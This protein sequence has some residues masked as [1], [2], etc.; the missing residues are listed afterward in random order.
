M[1][2]LLLFLPLCLAVACGSR[3]PTLSGPAPLPEHSSCTGRPLGAGNH[4]RTLTHQERT[5]NYRLHVPPGYDPTRPTP[6]VFA[7]HGFGSNEKSMGTLTHLSEESD[8]QGF[9]VVYVRGLTA[10]ELGRDPEPGF[11]ASGAWNSGVCCGAARDVGVDDV[12]FVDSLL[13]EL[14]TQVCLDTKRV[15][16]TGFSNGGFFSYRLA[17][18]RSEQFAAIAPVSG[19]ESATPCSPS[20][21]VPIMHFHGSEDRTIEVQG[22]T[23]SFLSGPYPAMS[24]VV[25]RWVSRDACTGEPRTTYQKGDSTCVTWESCA[26]GAAVTRCDIQGGGHTWPGGPDIPGLGYTTKDLDA[27][28][29]MWRFFAAHPR[30]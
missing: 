25:A 14:D 23:A 19:V 26:Q 1:R 16:A 4:D 3:A 13:A 28:R 7:F 20:R 17:C 29:E 30:P 6:V 2:S 18:E 21:P 5:R 12:G 11:G 22:G 24:D 9:L 10:A 15:Y 8:A 27:T